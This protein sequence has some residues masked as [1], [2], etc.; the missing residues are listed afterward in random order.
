L[1]AFVDLITFFGLAS[2][3]AWLAYAPLQRE[4]LKDFEGTDFFDKARKNFYTIND[5][6]LVSFLLYAAAIVVDYLVHTKTIAGLWGNPVYG[7]SSLY[8]I[9]GTC[10]VAGLLSLAAPM[11][12]MRAVGKGD[13]DLAT[14]R[15][16]GFGYTLLVAG[17]ATF[18]FII[19]IS[20]LYAIFLT[21]NLNSPPSPLAIFWILMCVFV[22]GFGPML[23]MTFFKGEKGQLIGWIMLVIPIIAKVLLLT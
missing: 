23:T 7:W 12:Y 9:I 16:H 2:F 17:S 3:F 22:P 11:W 4:L 20:S 13:M 6:F 18:D 21:A 14:D 10:F 15:L 1:V 19:S 8:F 5:Y